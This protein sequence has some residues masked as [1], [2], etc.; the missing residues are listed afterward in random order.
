MGGE[1]RSSYRQ[2]EAPNSCL[3]HPIA[4]REAGDKLSAHQHL[5]GSRGDLMGSRAARSKQRPCL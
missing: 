1:N 4:T 5:S 2:I 3:L